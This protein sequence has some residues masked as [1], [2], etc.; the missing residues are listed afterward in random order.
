MYLVAKQFDAVHSGRSDPQRY[1][2]VGFDTEYQ[3]YVSDGTLN[4]EVL[5]YQY[6]CSVVERDGDDEPVP[7]WSGLIKPKGPEVE[8]RLSLEDFLVGALEDGARQFPNLVFSKHHLPC[9]S[10]YE[11]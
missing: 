4:N 10:F 9:G 11:S 8:H 1:L 5:S 7:S 3:R 2:I 6:C